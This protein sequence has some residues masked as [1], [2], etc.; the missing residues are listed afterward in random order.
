M[1]TTFLSCGSSMQAVQSVRQDRETHLHIHNERG[2]RMGGGVGWR[3]SVTSSSG[4]GDLS[5]GSPCLAFLFI[6]FHRDTSETRPVVSSLRLL[7]RMM[8]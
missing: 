6:L 7:R 1:C 5:A 3:G 4:G 2:K 8:K